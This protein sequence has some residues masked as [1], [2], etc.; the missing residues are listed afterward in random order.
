MSKKR[1]RM[2]TEKIKLRFIVPA[3]LLILAVALISSFF[4]FHDK[5]LDAA[6]ALREWSKSGS[7]SAYTL[8]TI[9][10]NRKVHS[11]LSKVSGVRR[12]DVCCIF[13]SCP[14]GKEAEV[15]ALFPE[16]GV[17]G[18]HFDLMRENF[19]K[20]YKIQFESKP[21]R[22][23][24]YSMPRGLLYLALWPEQKEYSGIILYI[25]ILGPG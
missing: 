17:E 23:I 10:R 8:E 21:S 24:K 6:I 22:C 25:E 4:I 11:L 9:L 19:Q 7:C 20:Y 14:P 18:D 2:N 1:M 3:L 12:G 13:F 15:L 5:F 16:G